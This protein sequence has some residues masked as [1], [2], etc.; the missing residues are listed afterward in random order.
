M[1]ICTFSMNL[2]YHIDE[3]SHPSCLCS[4]AVTTFMKDKEL[5]QDPNTIATTSFTYEVDYKASRCTK[6]L[7]QVMYQGGVGPDHQ[8]VVLGAVCGMWWCGDC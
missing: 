5:G 2:K 1:T 6:N 4:A 8:P 7:I 3:L